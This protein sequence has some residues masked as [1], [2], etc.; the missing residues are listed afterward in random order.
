MIKFNIRGENI[1]VTDAIRQYVE[2]KVSKIEKYFNDDRDVTAY[3]N[4]RVYPNKNAKVEVT[5]PM[6]N[7]TLRA[8]DTS[9]DLYGSIDLVVDKL[10]RQIR[11]YKTKHNSKRNNKPARMAFAEEL[12]PADIPDDTE[13]DSVIVRTKTVDLVEMEPE[14]AVIQMEMLGHDFYMFT[15]IDNQTTSVVY[16]REDGDIGLLEAK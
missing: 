11:K 14:E 13:D 5:I 12:M 6:K 4:L 3:V 7:L 16:R 8:E 10:G 1:E 15:D 9:G 2:D